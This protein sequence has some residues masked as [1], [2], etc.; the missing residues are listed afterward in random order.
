[1]LTTDPAYPAWEQMRLQFYR[2]LMLVLPCDPRIADAD[3]RDL[4]RYVDS[5]ERAQVRPT[6][7]GFVAWITRLPVD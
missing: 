6:V 4:F 1:M 5:A 3:Y 7:A 2:E